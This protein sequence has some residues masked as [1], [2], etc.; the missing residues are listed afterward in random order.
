MC[1]TM[2]TRKEEEW[3]DL[4]RK[5][6]DKLPKGIELALHTLGDPLANLS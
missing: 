2:S 3:N 5:V 1:Q 6:L 4:L